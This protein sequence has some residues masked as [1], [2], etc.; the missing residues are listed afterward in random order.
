MSRMYLDKCYWSLDG[1][2]W[3][4]TAPVVPWCNV[5]LESGGFEQLGRR[6]RPKW[7]IDPKSGAPIGLLN[8]VAPPSDD[9]DGD[10]CKIVIFLNLSWCPFR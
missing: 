5:S 10:T 3:R 1:I 6:E 4:R 2:T 7:L 9:H 8:G